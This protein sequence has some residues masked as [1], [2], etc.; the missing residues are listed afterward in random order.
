[1]LVIN[2]KL[3]IIVHIAMYVT[4]DFLVVCSYICLHLPLIFLLCSSTHVLL[5]DK[6]PSSQQFLSLSVLSMF[7]LPF[8]H[9]SSSVVSFSAGN[10]T[11]GIYSF[12]ILGYL[13]SFMWPS[14]L[15]LYLIAPFLNLACT[16]FPLYIRTERNLLHF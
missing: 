14:E 13:R 9:V 7:H 10:F 8:L 6:F 5:S 11:F 1:M 4:A 15:S 16:V 12:A 3:C 2:R